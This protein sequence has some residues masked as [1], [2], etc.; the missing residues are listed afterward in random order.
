MKIGMIL[1]TNDPET[2]WNAFRFGVKAIANQNSVRVFL[3]GRG[4]EIED[5]HS[6]KFDVAK[7][8]QLFLDDK[9]EI[10][11]CG[12]CLKLRNKSE[13]KTCPISTMQNLVE[14]VESSDK[15]ITFA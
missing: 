1:N 4:V 3:L 11:A 15:I 2:V 10:L 5:I 8:V 7:Q 12:T 9:G 6:E 13:T 14:I